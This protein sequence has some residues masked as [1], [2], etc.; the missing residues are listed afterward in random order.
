MALMLHWEGPATSRHSTCRLHAGLHGAGCRM[1]SILTERGKQG[2][3]GGRVGA[4][5]TGTAQT[6]T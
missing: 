6:R 1:N 4:L 3:M 5:G 2:G